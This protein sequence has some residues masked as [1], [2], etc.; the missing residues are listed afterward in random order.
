MSRRHARKSKLP[1]MMSISVLVILSGVIAIWFLWQKP[2]VKMEQ[3][4]QS[5]SETTKVSSTNVSNTTT[6][7]AQEQGVTIVNGI[8]VV[9]KKHPLPSTYN[10]G[11]DPQAK[12]A[13]ERLKADMKA[14]GFSISDQYSGFR[15]YEY[16]QEV[17]GNYV[18]RD[19]VEMADTYSA[20]PGHSEHQSGLAFDILNGSGQLLGDSPDDTQAVEWLATHAHEYGF[21]IRFQKGKEAFT[22]YQAEPWHIR[23]VGEQAGEIYESGKS[24]EEYLNVSGGNYE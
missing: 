24:L 20:R 13:L 14:Q 1:I 23:Y 19:G 10:K 18:K 7:V 16:Q 6:T 15:S 3:S 22:G 17:Y 4:S 8:L 2:S 12:A 21:I 11:E 9:N 5:M